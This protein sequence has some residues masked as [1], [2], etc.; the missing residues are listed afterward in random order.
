MKIT[1]PTKSY[2]KNFLEK[3]SANKQL[4]VESKLMAVILANSKSFLFRN[5]NCKDYD[6]EMELDIS[7][8]LNPYLQQGLS[9]QKIDYFNQ[10]LSA[11]IRVLLLEKIKTYLVFDQSFTRACNHARQEF[12]IDPKDFSNRA[13]TQ[14]YYRNKEQQNPSS[15]Q[16]KNKIY[17]I[18]PSISH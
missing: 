17:K 4:L 1:I 2:I 7:E 8:N 11:H 13:L 10:L 9:N 18:C 16:K 14:Y 12:G 15:N 6:T 5:K 3:R